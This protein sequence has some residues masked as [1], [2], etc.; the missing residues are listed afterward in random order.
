MLL[1]LEGLRKPG[2]ALNQE[3]VKVSDGLQFG[4]TPACPRDLQSHPTMADECAGITKKT[5]MQRL[6][7]G[8]TSIDGFTP[9]SHERSVCELRVRM[10]ACSVCTCMN[11]RRETDR[12]IGLVLGWRQADDG[13]CVDVQGTIWQMV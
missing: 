6:V 7:I 8:K 3:R 12:Q 13:R 5:S 9:I 11:I 10:Q 4:D 1:K 2:H